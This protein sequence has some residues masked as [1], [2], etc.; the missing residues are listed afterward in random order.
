MENKNYFQ[1]KSIEASELGE[2][3]NYIAT[4]IN[5]YNSKWDVIRVTYE[6]KKHWKT[7]EL[8]WEDEEQ[9]IPMMEKEYGEVPKEPE[10]Y[11]EEDH[12]RIE[13]LEKVQKLLEKAM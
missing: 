11:T 5:D 1:R 2:V 7:G 4:R 3:Y 9:T 12:I 13:T 10:D 8:M 6:Q